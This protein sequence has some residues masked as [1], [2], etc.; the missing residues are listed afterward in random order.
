ME[1]TCNLNG[2][3]SRTQ[4][5]CDFVTLGILPRLVLSTRRVYTWIGLL[6]MQY[7]Y[8]HRVNLA[9]DVILR[10]SCNLYVPDSAMVVNNT[11]CH[12]LLS[13]IVSFAGA[14]SRIVN[15]T[16][17]ALDRSLIEHF[18]LTHDLERDLDLTFNLLRAMVVAHS[19]AKVQGR[20]SVGSEDRVKTNGWT[21]RQ[22]EAIALPPSLMRSVMSE[23]VSESC[24]DGEPADG[25]DMTGTGCSKSEMERLESGVKLMKRNRELIR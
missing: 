15:Q 10:L 7:V 16:K 19:R 8:P 20:Q 3:P 9:R 5:S 11:W 22:T 13:F 1:N 4:Q 23:R 17:T 2:I 6:F 12:G 24:M 25:E 21:D 14:A 18:S